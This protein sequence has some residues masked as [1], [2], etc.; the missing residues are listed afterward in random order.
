MLKEAAI[1]QPPS[2]SA[3]FIL[4]IDVLRSMIKM[5]YG[6]IPSAVFLIKLFENKVPG[7]YSA[8]SSTIELLTRDLSNCCLA[9][10]AQIGFRS[11][12]TCSS[13]YSLFYYLNV[14][15]LVRFVWKLLLDIL[16]LFLGDNFYSSYGSDLSFL[17]TISPIF[18]TKDFLQ[19]EGCLQPLCPSF[20]FLKLLEFISDE[21]EIFDGPF[22]NF[23]NPFMLFSN[24]LIYGSSGEEM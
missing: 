13:Y 17:F 23:L 2:I 5:F 15:S 24:L 1:Y 11:K 6:L 21:D 19:L 4:W 20:K 14:G 8:S 9:L 16:K 7:V 3:C 12:S 10:E 22:M 18:F